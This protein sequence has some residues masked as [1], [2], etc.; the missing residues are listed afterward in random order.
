MITSYARSVVIFETLGRHGTNRVSSIC[1]VLL[2]SIRMTSARRK[3]TTARRGRRAARRRTT[4]RAA[5]R[6]IE[7]WGADEGKG[8][9][10]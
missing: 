1:T 5:R 10:R 4:R 9:G 6:K 3:R 7:R 8:T 2:L